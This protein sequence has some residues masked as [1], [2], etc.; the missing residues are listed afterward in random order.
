M[1]RPIGCIRDNQSNNNKHARR[2]TFSGLVLV[3]WRL[4][5]N[6]H[7]DRERSICRHEVLR[8]RPNG[9]HVPT[10]RTAHITD[11]PIRWSRSHD[12]NKIVV[13]HLLGDQKMPFRTC[14]REFRIFSGASASTDSLRC[15]H[16]M[17]HCTELKP[18]FRPRPQRWTYSGDP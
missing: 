11:P 14:A 5:V 15:T 12:T 1:E 4:G 13:M 8:A 3:W 17:C 9:K 6:N 2:R 10:H 7:P 16:R 18:M